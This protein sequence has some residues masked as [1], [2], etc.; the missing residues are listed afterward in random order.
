VQVHTASGADT[1]IDLYWGAGQAVWQ[2][3][4]DARL[5]D[6]QGSLRALYRVP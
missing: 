4:E 5:F 3:G 6:S 1:V 2:S